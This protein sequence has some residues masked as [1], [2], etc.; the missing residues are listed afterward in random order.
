MFDS[1]IMNLLVTFCS[2]EK[3]FSYFTKIKFCHDQDKSPGFGNLEIG[4]R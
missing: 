2:K 4:T 1:H 3:L